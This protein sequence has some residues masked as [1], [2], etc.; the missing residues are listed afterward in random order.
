MN[1]YPTGPIALVFEYEV[2]PQKD[3]KQ[4]EGT[5]VHVS[6]VGMHTT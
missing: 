6:Y 3:N 4:L 1:V 5:V 2:E